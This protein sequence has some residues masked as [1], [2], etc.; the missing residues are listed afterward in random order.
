MY[1][2]VDRFPACKATSSLDL[3]NWA[4]CPRETLGGL[5]A[6]VTGVLSAESLAVDR[7]HQAVRERRMCALRFS[8]HKKRPKYLTSATESFWQSRQSQSSCQ[9]ILSCLVSDDEYS[10]PGVFFSQALTVCS[11]PGTEWVEYSLLVRGTDADTN[12][13]SLDPATCPGEQR[14][15]TV[16][17]CRKGTKTCAI[18]PCTAAVARSKTSCRPDGPP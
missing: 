6:Q 16:L 7:V 15:A 13:S 11:V 18:H 12:Y 2:C 5:T 4:T 9:H 3:S 8:R 14:G 10:F 17:C 1:C